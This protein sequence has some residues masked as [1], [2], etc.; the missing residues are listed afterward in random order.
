MIISTDAEKAYDKIQHPFMTKTLTKVGI[1]GTY[2][3]I[4]YCIYIYTVY[5]YINTTSTVYILHLHIYLY[6]YYSS[7][8]KE[9]I[10]PFAATR[11]QLEIIILSEVRK[12]LRKRMRNTI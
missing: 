4:I 12:R 2:L 1:E 7:I 6:E 10:I 5:I 3:K 11:M 9:K 8:K